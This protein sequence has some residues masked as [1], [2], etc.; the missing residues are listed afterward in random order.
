M[1]KFTHFIALFLAICFFLSQALADEKAVGKTPGVQA[2]TD[3]KSATTTAQSQVS[4]KPDMEQADRVS[5]ILGKKVISQKGEDLGKI[6]DIVLS[7]EGCLD[8]IVLAP[9]GLL[10]T[11][12]RLIPI[13]W[14]AVKTGAQADTIIV[15]MD[16]GQ[17][18]KAPNFES[19]KWPNF[20]DSE[21]YGKIREFFGAQK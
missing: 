17:L 15:D 7:K 16:K 9:G 14:K 3:E 1:K 13:P 20:T 2:Q 10:G 8:Y 12:D 5:K 18:E 6:E 11:G 19:K 21:W 4:E